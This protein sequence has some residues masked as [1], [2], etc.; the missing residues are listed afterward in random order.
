MALKILFVEMVRPAWA[1]ENPWDDWGAAESLADHH[2]T[3]ARDY[4]T[5][6]LESNTALEFAGAVCWYNMA[7]A[8]IGNYTHW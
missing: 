7:A 5:I 6:E 4:Q 8:T 2:A 3:V 1:G